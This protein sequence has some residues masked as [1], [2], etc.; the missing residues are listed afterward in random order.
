MILALICRMAAESSK[1]VLDT[2]IPLRF[3]VSTY[4]MSG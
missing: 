1:T 3:V 4:M 2:E